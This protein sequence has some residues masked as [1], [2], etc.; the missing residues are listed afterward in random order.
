[1][2]GADVFVRPSLSEGLGNSFLEAMALGLPII[3]TKVGGIPD[4]LKDGETGLFCQVN[5]PEDVA[6]K[7]RMIKGDPILREKLI[8]NGQGLVKTFYSWETIVSKFE[9][10]IF[11]KIG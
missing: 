11:D 8:K 3:G 10:E 7:I 2:Q 9:K 6:R 1:M 4:F 5:N